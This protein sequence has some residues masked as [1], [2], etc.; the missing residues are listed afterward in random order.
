MPPES[1]ASRR[2]PLVDLIEACLPQTQCGKCKTPGCR[3]YAEAIAAGEAINHCVPGGD[4]TIAE[5]AALLNV[6]ALPLD[7]EYGVTPLTRMVAFIREDECIGCTKCIQACPV[8]A[9]VGA[10][11]LMHTVII[12]DC[13]GCE[14][15]LPPCPVDCIDMV[16]LAP[17]VDP[18]ERKAR[19][20][21]AKAKFETRNQRLAKEQQ[22]NA[23]K[24]P[25]SLAPLDSPDSG[26]DKSLVIAA[27]LARTN[28]KKAERKLATAVGAGEDVAVLQQE[29]AD[30]RQELQHIEVRQKG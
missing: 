9:I 23:E 27:A 6:P 19:A 24:Q 10:A 7:P 12:E 20:A 2:I 4:E 21:Q 1:N 28:L 22:E 25:T 15:C 11:K 3:P 14:L 29:I 18:V 8:D 17:V 16:A 30:L 13:T 5:L 26:N